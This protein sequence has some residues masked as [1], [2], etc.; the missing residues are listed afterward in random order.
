M[1]IEID[2]NSDKF[3]ITFEKAYFIIVNTSVKRQQPEEGEKFVAV[4]DI[5]GYTDKSLVS[6]KT[7]L[8][9]KRY[10]VNLSTVDNFSGS[11]FVERCYS[12]VMTQPELAGGKKV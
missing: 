8:E 4:I 5:A 7:P 11:N 9:F 12:W 1:A 2:F 3:G 10:R 6:V